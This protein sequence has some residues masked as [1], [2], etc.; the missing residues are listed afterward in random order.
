MLGI[1][2]LTS[3]LAVA[4]ES[5]TLFLKRV[6]NAKVVAVD[7]YHQILIEEEVIDSLGNKKILTMTGFFEGQSLDSLLINGGGFS[8]WNYKLSKDSTYESISNV[9][10]MHWEDKSYSIAKDNISKIIYRRYPKWN[11]FNFGVAWWSLA[12]GLI[13]APLISID[14]KGGDFRQ[15]RYFW[16]AGPSFGL[17]IITFSINN[18]VKGLGRRGPTKKQ[19]YELLN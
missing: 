11:S 10:T 3:V 18:Y 15:Q 6:N 12:A 7:P 16:T 5:D 17:S 13:V 1:Y 9:Q 19:R 8:V 2:I 4:Q 14:Y